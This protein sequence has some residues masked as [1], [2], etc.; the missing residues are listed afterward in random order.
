MIAGVARRLSSP[1]FIGRRQE[2]DW[3]GDRLAERRA[4]HLATLLIGGEAGV[5]KTR[6]VTE[7]AERA[8]ASGWRVLVGH[9]L[10]LGE[11][12][13]PFAPIVEAFRD[14]PDLLDPDV[15]AR[16]LASGRSEIGNLVP[17]LADGSARAEARP[18]DEAT[19]ARLY[20]FILA[21]IGRLAAEAPLVL[22][23]E[24]LH[25]ADR[26]TR[27]LLRFLARNVRRG[28]L[29]IVA[30]FRTDELHRRHPLVPF[31]AELGRLPRVERSDLAR[32]SATETREQLSAILGHPAPPDLARGIHERSDGNPFFAEELL[33]AAQA[34]EAAIGRSGLPPDLETLLG[35]RVGR[36]TDATQAVLGVAAQRLEATVD[37]PVLLAPGRAHVIG[38]E[39]AGGAGAARGRRHVR[40]ERRVAR[41]ADGLHPVD[42]EVEQ[43]V[44]ADLPALADA[45]GCEQPGAVLRVLL[46]HR[47]IDATALP[48]LGAHA[49]AGHVGILRR[50]LRDL[51]LDEGVG[52]ARQPVVGA[53]HQAVRE[54]HAL[55]RARHRDLAL[56]TQG[57]VV[58]HAR[59]AADEQLVR[60]QVGRA[61]AGVGG[62]ADAARRGVVLF[63]GGVAQRG[64]GHLALGAGREHVLLVDL[65]AD[66][67]LRV[68]LDRALDADL[69]RAV[70][71][72]ALD[73]KS[74]V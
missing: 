64:L 61:E 30:T 7:F 8:A 73:R 51:V 3:L 44:L 27:D 41:L 56:A 49:D 54:V 31:L 35:E 15:L 16:V 62:V 39:V 9:C 1:T 66:V 34:P 69:A 32:L 71:A 6:L 36:L 12:G 23:I 55:A 14:L 67:E 63:G 70:L 42:A 58:G 33:A 38:G 10:E 2:R 28:P 50:A 25:W 29:L 47:R 53:D 21:M 18:A 68:D 17:T 45:E 13:L 20:E 5:G 57:E 74:V 72:T 11:S 48:G 26:S 37:R 52:L 60:D 4:D 24:D 59:R 22:E 46:F 43:Q 40:I 19:Q 65:T